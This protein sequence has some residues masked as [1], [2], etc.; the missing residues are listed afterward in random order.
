VDR[1][2]AILERAP[3]QH[4]PRLGAALRVT[5]ETFACFDV[6][7]CNAPLCPTYPDIPRKW[8]AR[9][10]LGESPA[11]LSADPE[12][13]KLT[14]AEA[15]QWLAAKHHISVRGGLYDDEPHRVATEWILDC[16]GIPYSSIVRSLSVARWIVSCWKDPER[17]KALEQLRVVRGP[18]GEEI[19]GRLL[20]RV[21]E[22]T[23][24]DLDPK[25]PLRGGV[26]PVFDRAGQRALV[27]YEKT[28]AKKHEPLAALPAWW[29]PIRCARLL[30]SGAELV[31]EGKLM[32]HCVSTYAPTVKS[33]KS[34][35]VSIVVQGE[36]STAEVE[37]RPSSSGSL[38]VRQHRTVR[39]ECPSPLSEKALVACLRLWEGRRAEAE[40]VTT[41]KRLA[42]RAEED[43]LAE[44]RRLGEGRAAG[45]RGPGFGHRGQARR[46]ALR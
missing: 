15:H 33:G 1:A 23:P 31:A 12:G 40:K 42:E 6:P 9:I 35:I 44:A 11:D 20:D 46:R 18:A 38:T 26:L 4:H 7:D 5:S 22:I 10:V 41:A 14:P 29:A 34:V 28:M 27:E 45:R 37:R 32:Q 19:H 43:R 24:A 13:A 16:G 2:I 21:D 3:P 8:Q 25:N 36:R 17:R 30:M 39:N